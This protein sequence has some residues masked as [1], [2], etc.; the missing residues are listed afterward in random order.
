MKSE[1]TFGDRLIAAAIALALFALWEVASRLGWISS[2]LFPSPTQILANFGVL[3][4]KDLGQNILVTLTRFL[5]GV[6]LG[7]IP[8]II[9]GLCIG[10]LPRV[11]RIADPFIA[12]IHPIPKLVLFPLFIV[13]FG[14]NEGAKIASV[15]LTVFFP[16]LINAAAGAREISPLYFEVIRSYGGGRAALFRHVVI[17]GSLPMI[18]SGIRIAATLGLLVT[19]AIEFSVTT[20]GIGSVMWLALQ[21]MRPED[22]YV[23]IVTISL[24]GIIINAT[25]QWLLRRLAP[26]QLQG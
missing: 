14:L 21:T 9:I 6:V 16:S 17:P 24:I 8:G 20:R 13:I 10:W 19:I 7:G 11:R 18:L 26:W 23:G 2:L 22:L 5:G 1:S 15:G 12:A 3:W 4:K 25:I